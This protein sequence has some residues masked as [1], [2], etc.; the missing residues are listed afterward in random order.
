MG[1]G[2]LATIM[3]FSMPASFARGH[4]VI[5]QGNRLLV[6]GFKLHISE[7]AHALKVG[8]ICHVHNF[9]VQ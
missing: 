5:I 2:P 4:Q 9:Y 7:S 8:A 3:L 1:A 6:Y